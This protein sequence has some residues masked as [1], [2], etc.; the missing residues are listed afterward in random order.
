MPLV[1]VASLP[2]RPINI[3]RPGTSYLR[4][5][6]VDHTEARSVTFWRILSVVSATARAPVV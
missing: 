4:D 6:S 1:R 5:A 3:H 2:R